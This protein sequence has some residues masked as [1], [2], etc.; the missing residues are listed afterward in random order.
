MTSLH[1]RHFS[2]EEPEAQVPSGAG[3]SVPGAAADGPGRADEAV[4]DAAAADEVVPDGPS[5]GGD[6][7]AADAAAGDPAPLPD[8]PVSEDGLTRVRHRRKPRRS[9]ARTALKALAIVVLLLGVA[10]GGAL[11]WVTN[12]IKQGEENLRASASK[13]EKDVE[14]ITYNGREYRRNEN[15]VSIAVLGFDST[16]SSRARGLVGQADAVMVL[17]LDTETGAM[18]VI[19][20]PRDSMV[21]IDQYDGDTFLGQTTAQL[22]LAFGY[23]DGGPL[24]AQRTVDA[25]SR[26]LLNQPIS[27]YFA[28]D[29]TGIADINDSVG[30]VT[31]TPLASVPSA[32]IYEG[33]QTTLWGKAA[34][35]YL[36]YRDTSVL[37]SSLDRM[38]RQQQYIQAFA[39]QL[40]SNVKAGDINSFV[41][42]YNTAL[43]YSV[44][45]L[46]F[47][48]FSYLASV[49]AANGIRG[50]G[51]T[52]LQGELTTDGTFAEVYLNEDSVR[53]AVVD[54]YYVPVE[55]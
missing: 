21:A 20:I 3:A 23:G 13:V 2:D 42:L 12:S 22:C 51:T 1:G 49:V 46:G 7:S 19:S 55:E 27:Y 41:N 24:S 31:L 35:D 29:M 10:A 16:D 43:S 28:I 9:R 45:N 33:Q 52:S 37:S 25:V 32:G 40:L 14:T 8:P 5:D 17:A 50:I 26:V 39:E 53:Q 18:K 38:A 36:H 34:F 44:T 6:A 4:A 30:G 48:E 11:L 15:I 54:V 47:D